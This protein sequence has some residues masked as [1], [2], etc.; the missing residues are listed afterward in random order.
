M[1]YGEGPRASF[2]GLQAAATPL[3]TRERQETPRLFFRELV[4]DQF[5]EFLHRLVRIGSFATDNQL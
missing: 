1:Q 3:L 5:F 4:G 2:F